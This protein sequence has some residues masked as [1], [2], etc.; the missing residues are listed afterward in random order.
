MASPV[1]TS[2]KFFRDDFPGAP[3]LNGVAGATIALFDACLVTGFGS[4][5]AASVTVA[6]GVCTVTL[7]SDAKNPN[8]LNSVIA[9]SGA[10]GAWTDLN[11]E[12]R[13]NAVSNTTLQFATALADGTAT[14]TIS[15]KT[16]AA[17][18]NKPY[19]GTNLAAFKSADVTTLGM[20]LR[21]DDTGTTTCQVRGY[22][23]MSDVNTGTGP[24]PTV[25]QTATGGFWV[26]SSAA[27]ST[28]VVWRLVSDTRMFYF[29]PRP[30]T[31][32]SPTHI[33]HPTYS[34]GDF[35]AHKVPDAYGAVLT[36]A[37][38][39]PG[40]NTSPGSVL[41]YTSTGALNYTPRGYAGVGTAQEGFLSP[42]TA[43]AGDS[44]YSGADATY[45]PFPPATDGAL[46]LAR[47]RISDGARSGSTCVP[48]GVFPG[49]Y[50]VPQTALG[51]LFALDALTLASNP[52]SG[53][54]LMAI[55]AGAAAG[56]TATL[57]GRAFMDIT[58][59][60]R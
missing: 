14:G 19:T 48:R 45:G 27:N 59:P 22:E 7:S 51:P 57:G 28:A 42:E 40:S 29:C 31:G 60:W 10:T 24:F 2:V 8:L 43:G 34:F 20:H 13:V 33:G 1:D 56:D 35:L 18:W 41:F 12:Q 38:S 9:V 26:K 55:Y 58:G 21:V 46:R 37:S 15:V 16:A 44:A 47:V 25:A 54:K 53:R 50:H 36:A 11:G 32:A 49:V 39:A 4:R 52:I 3:T 30:T 5:T 17:G 6:G 23:A